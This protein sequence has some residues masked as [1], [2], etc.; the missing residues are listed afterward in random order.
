MLVGAI[1]A[2]GT[3]A[4]RTIHFQSELLPIFPQNLPSV[5]GLQLFQEKF[6]SAQE[7]I[8][9]MESQ[10][11]M[12]ANGA[13]VS[14]IEIPGSEKL[15]SLTTKLQTLPDVESVT[16]MGK[17]DPQRMSRAVAWTI[18]NLPP[19]QFAQFQNLFTPGELKSRLQ[20]TRNRLSGVMDPEAMALIRLDPFR[21]TEW[22]EKQG[23]IH[24]PLTNPSPTQSEGPTVIAI[25]VRARQP[26]QT[27]ESC[28]AF[29][30]EIRDTVRNDY[31]SAKLYP[32]DAQVWLRKF[33][34]TGRPAIVAET[35]TQ[36]RHDMLLM[37][38]VAAVLI[39]LAFWLCYRS[40]VPLLLILFLQ[41]LSFLCGLIAA[42][43]LF[44]GL[45]VIGMGFSAILLGVSMDYCILVYHYFATAE[46]PHAWPT[47][48]RGIWLSAITTA[49][50]FGILYFSSFP[51]FKQ[52]AVLIGVGLLT[53][54]YF[55]T[56]LLPLLLDRFKPVA[57]P[58]LNKVSDAFAAALEQRRKL[59]R[60]S[61][62]IGIAI[63]V[64]AVPFIWNYP[65][66][67]S[68]LKS[69][70]HSNSE[71]YR[72]MELLGNLGGMTR[73]FPVIVHGKTLADLHEQTAHLGKALSLDLSSS[74]L[75]IPRG[76]Y[77]DAN[78]TKWNDGR[79]RMVKD[80]I[81]QSDFDPTW[82][83]STR[84]LLGVLDGWKDGKENFK[85][86]RSMT[87]NVMS[88]SDGEPMALVR[89]P[90]PSPV[91]PDESVQLWHRI[92]ASGT[93][94]QP[95]D[96][97][98]LGSDLNQTARGDFQRLSVWML[99]IVFS[100]CWVAH[101]AMRLV[102]LNAVALILSLLL[103][104]ALL[105][106]TGTSMTIMSLLAVPLLIGLVIDYSLHLILALEE[107]R[108]N[109]KET[110]RHLATPV[111]LTGIA[112]VIGFGSPLAS[113]QPSLQNF[114]FVMDL[115]II[116]AV[117]TGLILIPALYFHPASRPHYSQTLYR[118]GWF[119]IASWFAS[120]VPRPCFR[121]FGKS[122]GWLYACSHPGSVRIVQRNLA[123][124]RKD[125][126]PSA[127]A[128]AVFVN[129]GATLADYFRL[130]VCPHDEVMRMIGENHG[131]ENFKKVYEEGRGC[132]L[133][134]GHMSLFELGGFFMKDQGCPITV[135]T[136][137]EPSGALT[138][139]RAD[140]R[141]RWG[142]DT[143][144]VGTDSFA[145]LEVVKHLQSGKFVAVLV[146]RPY[147]GQH[148]A[149]DFPGGKAPFSSGILM[150]ALLAQC[151]VIPVTVVCSHSGKY[152]LEA[153]P[154]IY[155][156]KRGSREETVEH[157]M[158]QIAH[159]LEPTLCK[160][161]DQWYQFVALP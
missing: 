14:T 33:F 129:F 1:L 74:L 30:G 62:A 27:F 139:W 3:W 144:E 35:A 25:Q 119:G 148:I 2:A 107:S 42:R 137:P 47:L 155:L 94:C 158:R 121:A 96:W 70:R 116:S 51:G 54:A 109:L 67:N 143:L 85:E 69:L 117:A 32:P 15:E 73:T 131:A 10:T 136:L 159:T 115:G 28:Q 80:V 78:R 58:W 90:L 151:P 100:L 112:S 86:I 49:G 31:G 72:G 124:L 22:L 44:G 106:A 55:A 113:Q 125:P 41:G 37:A 132:L 122:C 101:R 63:F 61:V 19:E 5:Q 23:G 83:E 76:S 130:G 7:V 65:F 156:E 140:Y 141:A 145:L 17:S 150:L 64:I 104:L 71:A 40:L 99:L 149:V 53:T 93:R 8:V 95:A 103:L 146:D 34:L 98:L 147:Q 108:G 6:G 48:K 68:D 111:F 57:P 38:G 92:E 91:K 56:T 110:F 87:S 105:V 128:R 126:I 13:A 39:S 133:V 45:N 114:G 120:W 11:I 97:A 123:L 4:A 75:W 157:Y 46:G 20:K 77:M 135:L 60:W 12:N 52:L 24:L 59:V 26:L 154:P 82:G 43:I 127:L 81:A 9:V 153:H 84:M 142:V 66:Y 134:T 118:A 79:G 29:V 152:H 16:I 102:M 89:V 160:H 161:P 18:A 138:R 88:W 36:M 21:L 50:A